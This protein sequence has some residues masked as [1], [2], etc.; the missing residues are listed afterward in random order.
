MEDV[1]DT[2]HKL[3]S[4]VKHLD[5]VKYNL[6]VCRRSYTYL[7]LMLK[8]VFNSILQYL[9][10][11]WWFVEQSCLLPTSLLN[12]AYHKLPLITAN[13]L[14]GSHLFRFIYA[15]NIT[16]L[17]VLS[18]IKAQVSTRASLNKVSEAKVQRG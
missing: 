3:L 17:S 8:Q 14:F 12:Q 15:H 10:T 9:G 11:R 13:K 4:T 7:Q 2:L 1:V 5:R 18:E 6:S 16:N